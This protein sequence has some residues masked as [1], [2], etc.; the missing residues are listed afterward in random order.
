MFILT[1]ISCSYLVHFGYE[2]SIPKPIYK[3]H[4]IPRLKKNFLGTLFSH[5]FFLTY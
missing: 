1:Q 5:T 3:L 2:C 4:D